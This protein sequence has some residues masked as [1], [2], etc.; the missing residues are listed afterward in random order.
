MLYTGIETRTN[1]TSY[2]NSRHT[3]GRPYRNLNSQ[4]FGVGSG[5]GVDYT[6]NRGS[7]QLRTGKKNKRSQVESGVGVEVGGVVEDGGVTWETPPRKE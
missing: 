2:R 7:V 6:R 4:S 3:V 1:K 5:Y